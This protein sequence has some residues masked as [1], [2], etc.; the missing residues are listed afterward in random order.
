MTIEVTNDSIDPGT[1]FLFSGQA[2]VQ[3][4]GDREGARPEV[5]Q[6]VVVAEDAVVAAQRLAK[7]DP[8]FRILGYATLADYEETARRLRAVVEGNSTDW[9]IL[10]D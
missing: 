8:S 4:V 5:T 7:H 2:V 6:R 1:V 9:T 10:A 3:K